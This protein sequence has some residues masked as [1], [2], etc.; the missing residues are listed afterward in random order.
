MDR[1]KLIEMIKADIDQI[2]PGRKYGITMHLFDEAF[3]DV[4]AWWPPWNKISLKKG[5]LLPGVEGWI[6]YRD[7]R[8]GVVWFYRPS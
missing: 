4:L 6:I 2:P 8:L 1:S 7:E 5:E 3:P